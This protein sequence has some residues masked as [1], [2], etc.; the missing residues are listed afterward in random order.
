M[1][2][3]TPHIGEQ[4][5][6]KYQLSKRNKTNPVTKKKKKKKRPVSVMLGLEK[7]RQED[8]E[9]KP[10]SSTPSKLE[11]LLCHMKVNEFQKRPCS[12]YTPVI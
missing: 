6:K 8:L 10:S 3:Q 11:A 7:L 12:K 9:F 2:W 5:K 1:H 4:K